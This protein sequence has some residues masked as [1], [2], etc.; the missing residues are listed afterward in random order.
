[1]S[2]YPD[3]DTKRIED[4]EWPSSLVWIIEN[5]APERA[6]ELL[7]IPRETPRAEGISLLEGKLTTHYIN[8]IPH[9]SQQEYP[10]DLEIEEPIYNA[11]RW[12]AMAMVVKS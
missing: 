10:G 1:M 5:E 2:T 6:L 4:K 12:N 3:A 9:N 11:I 7:N 8:S